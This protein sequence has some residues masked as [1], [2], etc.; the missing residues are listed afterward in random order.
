[1]AG[2]STPKE[3]IRCNEVIKD[4][5]LVIYCQVG[6]AHVRSTYSGKE[7]VNVQFSRSKYNYGAA[8]AVEGQHPLN[9][10][11]YRGAIHAPCFAELVDD[12]G[13]ADITKK[14]R[15]RTPAAKK[16][17][18]KRPVKKLSRLDLINED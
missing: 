18:A 17:S 12:I 13:L 14:V 9:G 10:T 8:P 16:A 6:E 2:Y 7:K 1:M 4:R 11:S 5:D 15:D 3:C